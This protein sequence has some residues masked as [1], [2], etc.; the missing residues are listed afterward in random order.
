MRV[1]D[2][3][4]LHEIDAAKASLQ[5]WRVLHHAA[6]LG[7]LSRTRQTRCMAVGTEGNDTES[8]S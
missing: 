3:S 8:S 2:G 7:Q 5:R 4:H 1:G 6:K